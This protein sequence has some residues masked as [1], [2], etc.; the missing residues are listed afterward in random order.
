MASPSKDSSSTVH[1]VDKLLT[2]PT[3]TTCTAEIVDFAKTPLPEYT[4]NFA[5]LVH[6]LLTPEECSSL[7]KAVQTP[8]STWEQ[9][10]INIGGGRQM[11]ALEDRNCGRI[12]FDNKILAQRLLNRIMPLLPPEIVTVQDNAGITGYGPVKRKEVWRITR[13]NERLRFLKYTHGMYFREH[14]DGS[15]VTPDEKE[16]SLMTVHLYLNGDGTKTFA[17]YEGIGDSNDEVPIDGRPL[18][19]GSTRFFSMNL[20]RYFDV[21]PEMGSCVVFQH[22]DLVHSGEDVFQGTKYTVRADVMYKKVE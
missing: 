13:L 20:Q 4:G 3:P 16:R 7:L 15:Y 22:R 19:G 2:A 12:I 1:A 10:M 5:M 17:P 14:V 8:D 6:N 11:L 21:I 9:A 18:V